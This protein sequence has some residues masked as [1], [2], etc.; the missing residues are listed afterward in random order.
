MV[1]RLPAIVENG[2]LPGGPKVVWIDRAGRIKIK[3]DEDPR[4]MRPFVTPSLKV[5]AAELRRRATLAKQ[6][7]NVPPTSI[8]NSQRSAAIAA[9]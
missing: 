6:S 3:R 4:P 5:C 2:Q 7:V 9:F 1:D 8:Q